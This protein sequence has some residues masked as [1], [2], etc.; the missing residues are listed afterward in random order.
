[1]QEHTSTTTEKTQEGTPE[2]TP[3]SWRFFVR[4]AALIGVDDHRTLHD[5]RT[6]TVL[7]GGIVGKRFSGGGQ[8]VGGGVRGVV[9]GFSYG[10]RRRMRRL[11]MSLDWTRQPASWLTLT[12]GLA[13]V[14]AW[15]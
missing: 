11:L 3:G 10:S 5:V 1:M 2:S 13:C 8:Q 15:L 14:L 6:L 12:Y 9:K 7:P 4:S